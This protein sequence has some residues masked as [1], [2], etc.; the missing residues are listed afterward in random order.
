MKTTPR[1]A[2]IGC[3]QIAWRH[4]AQASRLGHL[5]AVCDIAENKADELAREFSAKPYYSID[6]LLEKEKQVEI[7][8]VCTPNGLHAAHCIQSMKAGKDVLCEKPMAISSAEAT[9]MIDAARTFQRKLYVVKQNRFNPPIVVLKSLLDNKELGEIFSFQINCFWNRPVAYYQSDWRGTLEMDGGILFTQF[10]HFIDLLYWCLGDVERTQGWRKNY[11][12]KNVI[13]FEDTG[14][15]VLELKSGAIGT[16]HYT[17]NSH[18]KN[19]EGSFLV[20]GEK[21][22]LRVGGQY[23]NELDYFSAEGKISPPLLKSNPSN[24]YGFYQGSMSNHHLVYETLIQA[25]DDPSL[26]FITTDEMTKTIEI[27]EKIYKGSPLLE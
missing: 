10:S 19:M 15:A 3:G 18:Q 5:V 9:G 12:H 1:F 4:A 20:F 21:G 14:V 24:E 6:E 2:I 13:Q 17:I 16:I 23:L 7:V 8:A 25:I 11:L 27:I 26:P 22:T